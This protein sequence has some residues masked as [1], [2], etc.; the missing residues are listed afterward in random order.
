MSTPTFTL[1]ENQLADAIAGPELYGMKRRCQDLIIA[2]GNI[3]ARRKTTNFPA[4]L[5]EL[6]HESKLSIST[7]KRAIDEVCA[8]DNG[9]LLKKHVKGKLKLE[10]KDGS[11]SV[12]WQRN[13]YTVGERLLH[14]FNVLRGNSRISKNEL[15][16][17]SPVVSAG[18]ESELHITHSPLPESELLLFFSYIYLKLEEKNIRVMQKVSYT[19][20]DQEM[21]YTS[22]VEPKVETPIV[23]EDV[24]EE[25]EGKTTEPSPTPPP[26]P[27]S[28]PLI[29]KP[30]IQ[31]RP[32][33]SVLSRCADVDEVFAEVKAGYEDDLG[34]LG[35]L[36]KL[37][38]KFG[39]RQ[40][41]VVRETFLTIRYL[42]T[43]CQNLPSEVIRHFEEHYP[44][45]VIICA[46]RDFREKSITR[47]EEVMTHKIEKIMNAEQREARERTMRAI[48]ESRRMKEEWAQ[49]EAEAK[50]YHE[51]V[52][53]GIRP[54]VDIMAM[55][56]EARKKARAANEQ[57]Q[58]ER[59][60]QE[61]YYQTHRSRRGFITP[62][63]SA[64]A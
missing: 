63:L 23:S 46:V 43:Y 19:S 26:S 49:Q 9:V 38:A 5:N 48:R 58:K 15:G 11:V 40:P 6:A 56:A 51:E 55:F 45:S 22:D 52:A 44:L 50:K 10:N 37:I 42:P 21:S 28:S 33:S 27:T 25:N 35:P 14:A 31:R 20:R 36:R 30:P 34:I 60:Q 17:K 1:T 2:L 64:A 7:V 47:W 32:L 12:Q 18:S 59:E 62:S 39:E 3:C 53:A 61:E 57:K 24:L 29:P 8:V 54:K 13:W 41:D 16:G 4:S